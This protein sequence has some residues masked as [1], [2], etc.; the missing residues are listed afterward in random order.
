MQVQIGLVAVAGVLLVIAAG[1]E[2]RERGESAFPFETRDIVRRS[3]DVS[4][5]A[6]RR[7]ELSNVS[8]A[9][10]VTATSGNTIELVGE[11]TVR[12]KTQAALDDA[13]RDSTPVVTQTPD[14]V[15][16]FGAGGARRGCD[17]RSPGRERW[18]EPTSRVET[19]FT[20]RVPASLS[21]RLCTVNGRT[22]VTGVSA[23]VAVTGVNGRVEVTG[24]R[25][26][27]A[28]TTVNGGVIAAF[29]APPDGA[30]SVKTV[31]GDVEMTLPAATTADV[32]LNT[33]NGGLFTDFETTPLPA[34]S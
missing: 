28:I 15:V 26:P 5:S 21:L 32:W 16:V 8:G 30:S 4:G 27:I 31:N 24:A 3:L 29:V 11:R 2:P 17:E 34:R 22:S 14:G 13:R 1:G 18:D 10:V 25:G 20:I 23:A 12:A 7:L 6:G 19:S 9:I 33:R